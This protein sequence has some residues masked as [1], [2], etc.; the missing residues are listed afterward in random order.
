MSMAVHTAAGASI[1]ISASAP[2]TF[3]VAG[4]DALTLT[5]V[6]EV[7]DLGEFG[8]EYALVTHNPLATRATI[9]RK[10]SY[11]EGQISLQLA[12]DADDA[13]QI[14]LRAASESDA[15]H[16][17]GITDQDG[18][19]YFF[20]AQVMSFKINVG[21]V[22]NIVTATVTLEIT[23]ATGGVGVIVKPAS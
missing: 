17:F 22:D 9:K 23:S 18:T 3:N 21:S 1:G 6:G 14:L 19:V 20:P 5:N 13:G 11:N 15:D 16:Y 7:T 10:G 2:A 8:R 12:L 4:Y